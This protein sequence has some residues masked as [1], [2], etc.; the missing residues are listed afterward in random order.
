MSIRSALSCIFAQS[1]SDGWPRANSITNQG[2]P[3]KVERAVASS[4]CQSLFLV[5]MSLGHQFTHAPSSLRHPTN[6]PFSETLRSSAEPCKCSVTIV[7]DEHADGHDCFETSDVDE[8]STKPVWNPVSYACTF[9]SAQCARLAQ[10]LA[11]W[12]ANE[13]QP[14]QRQTRRF[15]NRSRRLE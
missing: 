1:T 11:T 8:R 6:K 9:M 13:H 10:V 12:L 14:K 7:E 2:S 5:H 4:A 15:S 3:N